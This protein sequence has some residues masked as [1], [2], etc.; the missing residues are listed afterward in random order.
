MWQMIG[1]LAELER[2]LISEWTRAGV[3]AAQRR[4]VK[5]GRK[6][7]LTA[8]QIAH[9]RK[10]M[11]ARTGRGRGRALERGPNDA[12]QGAGSM[13]KE[14]FHA[15]CVATTSDVGDGSRNFHSD[16]VHH[17]DAEIAEGGGKAERGFRDANSGLETVIRERRLGEP[18]SLKCQSLRNVGFGP[19]FNIDVSPI[20]KAPFEVRFERVGLL[21]PKDSED[22]QYTVLQDAVK[23]GFSKM[24]VWLESVISTGQLGSEMAVSVSYSDTSG[25]RYHSDHIIQFDA[26]AQTITAVFKDH[27]KD[28]P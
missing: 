13:S 5:F 25:N 8:Q 15:L 10:R 18:L 20:Q 1:V 19:A 9:A 24:S 22:L 23:S 11:D 4:G 27:R 21:E 14:S 17:R 16:L 26:A 7:K 3:K 2:S 28:R 6:P 12:L